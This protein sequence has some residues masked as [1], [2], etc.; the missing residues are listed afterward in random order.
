MTDDEFW[1]IIEQSRPRKDDCEKQA[2]KLTA[3]LKRRTPEEILEFEAHWTK[4]RYE[5]YRWD[6]YAVAYIV[7]GS[8]SDDGFEYFRNWLIGQG[9]EFYEA[10]LKSPECITERVPAGEEVECEAL[11]YAAGYAYEARTGQPLPDGV[12]EGPSEPVG[13]RWTDEDLDVLYP[14]LIAFYEGEE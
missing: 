2:R 3:I 11:L 8:G 4:R 5:T 6:L 1:D 7:N 12:W 13:T 9:R 10:M 14:T